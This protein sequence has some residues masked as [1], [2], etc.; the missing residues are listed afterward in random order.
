MALEDT[1]HTRQ[2]PAG[3]AL[4]PPVLES[5]A[6]P[7]GTDAASQP[8]RLPEDGG[9]CL[10]W[11]RPERMRTGTGASMP[12]HP[13]CSPKES[14]PAG[15][16][17]MPRPAAAA[18]PVA[19]CWRESAMAGPS[20]SKEIHS[21]RCR[22]AGC[23]RSGRRRCWDSMT[24]SVCDSPSARGRQADWPTV[25]EAIR[26]HLEEIRKDGGAVRFL[27]GPVT[28]PTTR[29][30]I[31]RFLEGFPE[32]RHVVLPPRSGAAILEA[33][34][35]THGVPVL[36]RY[37]FDK[38]RTIVSFDADFLGRWISPVE[39]AAAYQAGRRLDDPQVPP[40]YHVQFESR[41]SLTGSKADRRVLVGPGERGLVMSH[42]AARLAAKASI[43]LGAN[44]LDEG[45]GRRRVAR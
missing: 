5:A 12:W 27:T 22:A 40:S 14:F 25:D 39:F 16:M 8:A 13:S 19:D 31:Q 42:L 2:S 6:V 18:V 44:D 28:S 9:V 4:L 7:E 15:C 10:R 30:L 41:L 3:E 17:N 26:T 23:A 36:P 11:R 24:S 33:H 20:N 37:H 35:R 29:A 32:A 43:D 45:A 34:A 38:A 21:I 1:M